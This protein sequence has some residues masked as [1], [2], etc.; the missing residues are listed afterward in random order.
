MSYT[1]ATAAEVAGK[2]KPT[3]WR[4]VKAGKLSA[5]RLDDG[6]FRID[7]AELDRY[8]AATKETP[9]PETAKRSDTAPALNE[10]DA[11]ALQE[12]ITL[13][14]KVENLET[15]LATERERVADLREDRDGWREQAQRL[16]ITHEKAAIVVPPPPTATEAR[17]GLLERLVAAVRG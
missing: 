6:S 1:L 2:T 17:P 16:A 13:R 7:P 4:A 10:M 5:T 11:H 9:P 14:L 3:I 8:L 12:A 15:L